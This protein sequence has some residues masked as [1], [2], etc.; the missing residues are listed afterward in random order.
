M[1][2]LGPTLVMAA[3][4]GLVSPRSS[5]AQDPRLGR[6]DP[7]VRATVA[8]IIDTSRDA[9]LP[10]DPLVERALEGATKHAP[11]DRIIA[12]VR[13]LAG[14]LAMARLAL[15][16]S[17]TPAEL[18][19]AASALHAGV[20]PSDL[21]LLRQRR[22]KP[23]TVALAVLADLV[24]SGVPP[25]TAAAAVLTLAPSARDDQMSDFRRIVERDIALGAPPAAAAFVRANAA[26]RDRATMPNPKP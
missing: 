23:L 10:T 4:L 21:T 15:G 6:L 1:R 11:A 12:A 13:R 20:Q 9:G 7:S 5:P 8:A 22:S 2:N 25:D 3:A 16:A 24:A 19:A 18:N 26:L 14:E 17:S